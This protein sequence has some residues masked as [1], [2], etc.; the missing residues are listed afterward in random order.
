MLLNRIFN[1]SEVPC[2]KNVFD[3]LVRFQ[4]GINVC[5][6]L[7]TE[8]WCHKHCDMFVTD[9]SDTN[10][11]TEDSASSRLCLKFFGRLVDI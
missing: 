6:V 9:I 1:V 5:N 7:G 3:E 8:R 10:M 2:F 11:N 4:Y